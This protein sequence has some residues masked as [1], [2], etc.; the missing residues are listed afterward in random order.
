MRKVRHLACLAVLTSVAACAGPSLNDAETRAPAS[1]AVGSHEPSIY[2]SASELDGLVEPAP[3]GTVD[4][5][6]ARALALLDLQRLQV[7]EKL[8]TGLSLQA[9][10]VVIYGADGALAYYEF[11]VVD[12]VGASRGA[13]TTVANESQGPAIAF[14][15]LFPRSFAGALQQL[16][17]AVALGAGV[18]LRVIANDYPR[19]AIGVVSRSPEGGHLEQIFDAASGALMVASELAQP[20]SLDDLVAAH[21]EQAAGLAS[22]L[23]QAKAYK[24]QVAQFWAAARANKAALQDTAGRA[25]PEEVVLSGYADV[26]DNDWERGWCGPS[27]VNFT[28]GFMAH[29]G[30]IAYNAADYATYAELDKALGR[31]P[32][33]P[34]L[35]W[36]IQIGIAHFAPDYRTIG[37]G[38]GLDALVGAM[39]ALLS[40][41]VLPPIIAMLS[42]GGDVWS[43][44]RRSVSDDGIPGIT[45]R[46]V[47]AGGWQPHYRNVV[48]YKV[49]TWWLLNFNYF[50]VH[51]QNG[52]DGSPSPGGSATSG[53][54]HYNPLYHWQYFRIAAR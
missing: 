2:S 6:L 22:E 23:R 35:P 25:T 14:E 49:S 38:W 15:L 9:E 1:F 20:M 34:T 39:T 5:R 26:Q 40:G 31:L 12:A 17:T 47:R 3:A 45:L 52:I 44:I 43:S 18:G 24:A 36:M 51:D 37:S 32:W 33:G 48:G 46:G 30:L 27:A 29:R 19:Y 13:I 10:P 8:P 7:E 4:W 42:E 21:P 41:Q 54:E 28:L 16:K 11:G 50:L 53:W